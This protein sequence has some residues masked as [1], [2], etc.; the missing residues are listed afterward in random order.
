MTLFLELA[1]KEIMLCT[2]VTYL[3]LIYFFFSFKPQTSFNFKLTTPYL[4]L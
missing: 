1:D 3:F 2:V 4:Y